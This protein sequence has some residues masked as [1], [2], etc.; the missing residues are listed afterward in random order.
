MPLDFP[1]TP[2][3]GQ[4]FNVGGIVWTWDGV[5]WTS[6]APTSPT[7]LLTSGGTMSGP[8]TL[9]GNAVGVLDAVPLQQVNAASGTINARTL[10]F[11]GDGVTSNTA[12]LAAMFAMT[13]NQTVYFPEGVYLWG[14]PSAQTDAASNISI[15]G[16]GRDKTIFRLTS[17]F[18]MT[19][20][21]YR[22]YQRSGFSLRNFTLDLNSPSATGHL[23]CLFFRSST[24]FV[25]D[26]VAIINGT[27]NMMAIGISA[28]AGVTVADFWITNCRFQFTPCWTWGGALAMTAGNPAVGTITRGHLQNNVMVG[29]GAQLDGNNHIVTG[30]EISG[31][32]S[33]SLYVIPSSINP[34][35]GHH[36]ITSN[37]F[38]DTMA[39]RLN[40]D[41][42][43]AGGIELDGDYNIMA[44]NLA[45]RC[46]GPGFVLFGRNCFII[47]NT[48]FGCG[49][50]G[51]LARGAYDQCGF[52]TAS[53]ASQTFG[54]N[55]ILVGN[56][57]RDDGGGFQL[58][59]YY[60]Q[61]PS[62]ASSVILRG[63]VFSGVTAALGTMNAST[64]VDGASRASVTTLGLSPA[65]TTSTG[66]VCAGLAVLITPTSSGILDVRVCMNTRNNTASNG[67]FV[68]LRYGAGTPPTNGTA[69]A[70]VGAGVGTGVQQVNGAGGSPTVPV[71][72]IGTISGLTPGTT[73]WID[74]SYSAI[75]GGSVQLSAVDVMAS[76]R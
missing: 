19:T 14:A 17:G 6:V 62:V 54:A 51:A 56:V 48:S 64:I 32:Y 42:I 29:C 34:N 52:R 61:T 75:T 37:H 28:D 58:F 59:G 26:N 1:N 20:N 16:A 18:T 40:F 5:K 46:A 12:A 39:D 3:L 24:N 74:I 41:G 50:I 33:T 47:G 66:Q 45:E 72:L 35:S 22:W 2:T 36:V 10:G 73:Y 65:T 60:E 11:V 13:G 9:A 67:L 8:I 30:N 53:Q 27:D 49:R 7:Y 38:H 15:L 25:V 43:P 23:N 21:L 70:G 44:N 55:N 63:N 76:E 4:Q 71:T 57:A 68:R 69:I 31:N